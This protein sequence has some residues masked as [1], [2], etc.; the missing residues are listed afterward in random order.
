MTIPDDIAKWLQRHLSILCEDDLSIGHFSSGD[1][2][3]VSINT[4]ARWQLSVDMIYRTLKCDLIEV[5]KYL[6]CHD[7]QSFLDAIRR[8]GP[9]N[10]ID[11]VLW[12]AT[13]IYGTGK[14]EALV[15]SFFGTPSNGRDKLNPAFIEALEQ[16][17]A[18]NGVPWSDKPLL[19][20]MPVD[21]S[22]PADVSR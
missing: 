11:I 2:D 7:R 9:D 12:N 15:R 6:N 14:L 10:H 16:I 4:P 1:I 3:S 18:E 13:L 20:I 8:Y 5:F 17:F 19:P 21:A 22:A